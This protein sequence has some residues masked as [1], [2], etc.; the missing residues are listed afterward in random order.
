MK[1]IKHIVVDLETHT[2]IKGLAGMTQ[3]T[4]GNY[5]KKLIKDKLKEEKENV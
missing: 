3:L 1:K 5:I 2:L 4:M